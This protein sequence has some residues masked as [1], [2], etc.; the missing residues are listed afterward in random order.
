MFARTSWCRRYDERVE[1]VRDFRVSVVR[2]VLV[3]QRRLTRRVSHP[4]HEFRC[5]SADRSRKSVGRVAEIM[6]AEV[7]R[8]TVD[9]APRRPP[10]AIDCLL[11]KSVRSFPGEETPVGP[12]SRKTCQVALQFI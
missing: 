10:V 7:H 6:E 12:W 1:A 4:A 11:A 8:Q 5:R 9:A 3:A 2:R